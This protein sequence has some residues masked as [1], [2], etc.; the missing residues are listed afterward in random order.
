MSAV[1]VF[2]AN[3]QLILI[4]NLKLN[5][6]KLYLNIINLAA[7]KSRSTQGAGS[8]NTFAHLYI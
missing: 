2:L 3:A 8:L 4:S 5:V 7:Y 6:I 1:H